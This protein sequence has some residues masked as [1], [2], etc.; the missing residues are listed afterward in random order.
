MFPPVFDRLPRSSFHWKVVVAL[1]ITWIIDGLEVTL[2]GAISGMLR[3]KATLYLTSRE[4]GQIASFYAAGTV[5]GALLFGRLMDLMGRKKLF[6]ITVAV[7][8]T[9]TL[10]TASSR[11]LWSFAAFRLITGR[12]SEGSMGQS[13]PRLTSLFPPRSEDERISS[14]TG[15]IGWE[16]RRGRLERSCCSTRTSSLSMWEGV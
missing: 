14:S 1:G 15:A 16:Q 4:I 10:M 13:I 3:D 2:T 9:G 6:F 7:Y 5:M 8:L 11:G 12:A